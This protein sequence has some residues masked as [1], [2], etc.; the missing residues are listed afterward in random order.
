M[1]TVKTVKY[2]E[3]LCGTQ[4][5]M[6]RQRQLLDAVCKHPRAV[7][8]AGLS[9]VWAILTRIVLFWWCTPHDFLNF[10]FK[11]HECLLCGSHGDEF[12]HNQPRMSSGLW[13][14][15][16][17]GSLCKECQTLFLS[18]ATSQNIYRYIF[19]LNSRHTLTALAGRVVCFF[20]W[21]W[22]AFILQSFTLSWV[23]FW[24]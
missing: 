17:T 7:N 15:C 14:C 22:R 8:K 11:M 4:E 10:Q 23:L 16:D 1:L 19:F 6:E 18:V 12:I 9:P 3:D 2:E 24:I 21:N 13:N 20:Y 5:E